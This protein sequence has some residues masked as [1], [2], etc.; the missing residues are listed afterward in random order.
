LHLCLAPLSPSSFSLSLFVLC[1]PPPLSPFN[2]SLP[3][4][5]TLNFLFYSSSLF[6][7]TL[8]IYFTC[9]FP[10]IFQLSFTLL[11]FKVFNSPSVSLSSALPLYLSLVCVFPSHSSFWLASII[12]FN[13][14]LYVPCSFIPSLKLFA[15]RLLQFHPIW[16]LPISLFQFSLQFF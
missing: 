7:R 10:S 2:L 13:L 12:F 16:S 11:Y 15:L 3:F 5:Y 1:L 4:Y 14:F 9:L 6:S 8:S